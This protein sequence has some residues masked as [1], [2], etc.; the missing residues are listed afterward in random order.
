MILALIVACLGWV[1]TAWILTSA[2]REKDRHHALQLSGLLNRIQAP[3][4]TVT[5][6]LT[7]SEQHETVI[8]P[9][10]EQSYWHDVEHKAAA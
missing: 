9:H 4:A 8:L 10:T 5:Q 6:D 3:E 7:G 2:L 1:A